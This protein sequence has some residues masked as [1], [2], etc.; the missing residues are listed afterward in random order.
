MREFPTEV[1]RAQCKERRPHDRA[2]SIR[3]EKARPRQ[4]IDAS[5]E[6]RQAP[7]DR[8]EAPEEHDFRAAPH[9]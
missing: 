6:S 3:H 9:E 5:E 2:R 4:L 8:Y 1:V 7:K